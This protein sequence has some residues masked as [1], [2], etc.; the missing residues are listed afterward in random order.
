MAQNTPQIAKFSQDL[1][2]SWSDGR[3]FNGFAIFGVVVPTNG[4]TEWAYITVG[5]NYPPIKVPVW[6]RIP[7]QD[8]KFNSSLGLWYTTDMNPPG[9]T[10]IGYYYD[11]TGRQIAGPT[12]N[13]TVTSG[14]ITPTVPTLTAPSGPGTN[15]VPN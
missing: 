15:P 12:A 14:T 5:E 6:A 4:V 8:G 7:I 3:K 2:V 11:S 10:Y 1:T 9:V 13:F